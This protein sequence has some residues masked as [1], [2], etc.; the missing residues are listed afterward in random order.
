MF[1]T[2]RSAL[3]TPP[4][5]HPGQQAYTFLICILSTSFISVSISLSAVTLG[6]LS[7]RSRALCTST[8]YNVRH[9][10]NE[11]FF[12]SPRVNISYYSIAYNCSTV[13]SISKHRQGRMLASKERKKKCRKGKGRS[14]PALFLPYRTEHFGQKWHRNVA[15]YYQSSVT[16]RLYRLTRKMAPSCCMPVEKFGIKY[17]TF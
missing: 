7:Q 11:A 3:M 5:C 12:W 2:D 1:M 17:M 6:Y 4:E 13:Y 8:L 16:L 10:W 14:R 15:S 9:E